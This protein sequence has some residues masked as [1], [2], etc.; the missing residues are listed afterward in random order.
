MGVSPRQLAATC[1]VRHASRARL[2]LTDEAT[3][4]RRGLSGA[5]RDAARRR[6]A[7]CAGRRPDGRRGQHLRDSEMHAQIDPRLA[8]AATSR[9]CQ[10][11]EG[12]QRLRG[13]YLREGDEDKKSRLDVAAR[14]HSFY[15]IGPASPH[16]Y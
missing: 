14:T 7:Q 6:T 13:A 2:R 10:W 5:R 4:Q 1:A 16:S 11:I 8:A 15:G 9:Y 12:V 3:N